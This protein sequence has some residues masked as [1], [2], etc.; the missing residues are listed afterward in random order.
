MYP[1]NMKLLLTA[2]S[3]GFLQVGCASNTDNLF[4]TPSS[5]PDSISK[6]SKKG[7]TT[8]EKNLDKFLKYYLIKN[9]TFEK[10]DAQDCKAYVQEN[11][12]F[13]KTDQCKAI[14]TE[15]DFRCVDNTCK[16]I[17][18]SREELCTDEACKALVADQPELCKPDDYICLSVLNNEASR[19]VAG[20]DCRAFID[21]NSP[22]CKTDQCKAFVNDNMNF[23]EGTPQ[24][25]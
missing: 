13:C 18:G 9:S 2:L 21:K 16:A 22:D 24:R 4:R 20:S 11:Q 17:L 6:I 25:Q 1:N 3:L 5:L 23:C 12:V 15:Q 7:P 14:L 19:C 10:I 8:S